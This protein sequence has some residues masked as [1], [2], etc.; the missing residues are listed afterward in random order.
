MHTEESTSKIMWWVNGSLAPA[1]LW[2]VFVFGFN[3]ALVVLASI[4]GAVLTEFA[5]QKALGRRPTLTDGSAVCTGLLLALTVNPNLP[6][7]QAFLGAMF[8]IGLGKMIFGGLGFNLFNPA[9]LGRAFLMATFPLNMTSGWAMPR[10]WFGAPLDAV[11]TATPLAV[12]K[13]QGIEAAVQLVTSPAGLWNAL[14]LGFRPGSIGEVSLVLVA[15]GGG[16][17]LARRIITLAIPLSVL[18]GVALSTLHTGVPLLHLMSGGLWIGA[19]YMATDYVTS[20][21]TTRAQIAFG[22]LIG[23]LT[24]IIRVYGGY[25]EGI[26]YAILI[27]NAMA[28]ALDLWFRPRRAAI[29]GSPS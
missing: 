7:W 12:L 1:V 13:E 18:A 23:L 15:L 21:S 14:A 5:S 24:G 8:A 3:A 27:A 19:F 10:P 28:P 29:A 20:P 16:I 11:T 25:P 22:L 2:G 9:L 26:C 6:A 17:L 4:A